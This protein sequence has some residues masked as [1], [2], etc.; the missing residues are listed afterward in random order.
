MTQDQRAEEAIEEGYQVPLL[1]LRQDGEEE[2]ARGD[3]G[4]RLILSSSSSAEAKVLVPELFIGQW[5]VC[6]SVYLFI[7]PI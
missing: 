1:H 6:A 2:E 3:I 5:P 4:P 7:R